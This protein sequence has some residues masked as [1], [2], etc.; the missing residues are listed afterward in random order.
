MND[1]QKLSATYFLDI[2]AE[3]S[4]NGGKPT[5]ADILAEVRGEPFDEGETDDT[6]EVDDESP[7]CPTSLE[8]DQALKILQ[9]FSLFRESCN[10]VT[11]FVEKLNV[12]APGY[13]SKRRRQISD[14]FAK[15]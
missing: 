4:T 6:L 13:I 8:V 2:D 7:I 1:V 3:L 12:H 14:F 15:L 10:E 5:D 9:R 11:D